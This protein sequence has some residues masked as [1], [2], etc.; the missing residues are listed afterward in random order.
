MPNPISWIDPLGLRAKVGDCP[1]VNPWNQ[2]QKDMKGHFAN[3]S[4]AAKSYQRMKD[5]AKMGSNAEKINRPDPSD[6][7]PESFIDAHI[8]LFNEEG[9]AFIAIQG[10][11]ENPEYTTLPQRK[12]VGLRSEMDEVISKYEASGGD[13]KVLVEELSLGKNVDLSKEKIAYVVVEPGDERLAYD[14]PTGRE[15]GAYENE[16]VPGGKTKGGTVEAAL[17]GAEDIVHDNDVDNLV[18]QFPGS[19]IIKE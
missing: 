6:Y 4:K 5:I 12:F 11:M 2:F 16:W 14:I 19:K 8:Q 13:W 7:L 10:W 1:K 3:S 17:V 18:K 9:S 15:R